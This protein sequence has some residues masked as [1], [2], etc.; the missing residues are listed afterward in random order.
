MKF[1]VSG[2]SKDT[3]ARM[4]IELDADS[5]GAAEKKAVAQGIV[6]NHCVAVGDAPIGAGPM[7]NRGDS[8]GSSAI[9][10]LVKLL[11]LVIIVA[12]IAYL[13]WPSVRGMIGR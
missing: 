6:V 13:A 3:G 8:K 1:K 5:K 11:A 9:G 4:T 12:T 7:R 2:A 10:T